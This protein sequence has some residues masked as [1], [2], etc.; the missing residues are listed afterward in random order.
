M[1]EAFGGER[2]DLGEGLAQNELGSKLARDC[3][4]KLHGF[5]FEPTFDR[6]K[7]ARQAIKHVTDLLERNRHAARGDRGA[8][9]FGRGKA[10][11]IAL[12]LGL[13]EHDRQLRRRHRLLGRLCV[14]REVLIE[15]IFGLHGHLVDQLLVA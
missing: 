8:F 2:R 3:G 12:A 10:V 6:G 7:A 1:L 15:Q 11:A 13:G 5:G 9:L 14:R 4:R